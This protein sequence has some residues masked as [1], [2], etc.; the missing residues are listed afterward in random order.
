MAINYML[1]ERINSGAWS[2]VQND[3]STQS[4]RSGLGYGVYGYRVKACNVSGCS[5][6][7]AVA[8]INSTPPPAT[9]KITHSRQTTWRLKRL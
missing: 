6:Y 1:E 7:S 9:P 4:N 3:G 2:L 8:S 5:G